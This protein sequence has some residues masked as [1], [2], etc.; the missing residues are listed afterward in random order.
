MATERE[1]RRAARRRQVRRRR[2]AL[3][4]ALSLLVA[5]ITA[6][7]LRGGG[8]ALPRATTVAVKPRPRVT[9]AM[10]RAAAREAH[11]NELGVV[12]VL[13]HH[14]IRPDGGDYDLTAAQ[15]KAELARLYREGYV[16]VRAQDLALGTLDVPAGKTPVVMTFDDSTKEQFSYLPNGKIKPGTAIGIMLAFAR[17]HP[18][19]EPAGTFYVNREPFAGVREGPAMLRWLVA[20]GFEIGNH[21]KDHL[22]FN[23]LDPTQIQRQLVLGGRVI[24]SA[25][26]NAKIVTMALPLGVMPKPAVLARRGHWGGD[27]YSFRGVFLVG[28]NPAPSPFSTKFEPYAIPRIRTSPHS[29]VADFGSTFWLDYL[30]K[31]AGERYV[32][33]GDPAHVSFPRAHAQELRPRFRE[34]ALAY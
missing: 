9:V 3:A 8:D 5:A 7:V 4:L 25:I 14:Q 24:T 23:Q 21:T 28:A 2:V 1:E 26:P 15:F 31:N 20:H 19:F 18:G 27:T 30:A 10:R 17:K 16:P 13:M 32:S 6:A 12:P 29:G 33:D 22:P 34:R 11:A